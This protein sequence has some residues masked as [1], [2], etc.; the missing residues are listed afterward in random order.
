MRENP[1]TSPLS[2]ILKTSLSA[3]NNHLFKVMFLPYYP[4]FK[5]LKVLLTMSTQL[6][7]LRHSHVNS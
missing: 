2:E 5:F 6:N 1:G 4:L 7:A 3:I